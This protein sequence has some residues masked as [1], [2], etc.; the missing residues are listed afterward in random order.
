MCLIIETVPASMRDANCVPCY[1][2]W[3]KIWDCQTPIT[4]YRWTPIPRDGVLADKELTKKRLLNQEINGG[5]IH[6]KQKRENDT[7]RI[8]SK[9]YAFGVIAYGSKWGNDLACSLLYIPRLD[10]SP[11]KAKRMKQIA[12]WKR[13]NKGPTNSEVKRLFPNFLA[14]NP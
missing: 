4:P 14:P 13:A 11:Q 5:A 7:L 3:T 1:K 10:K 8:I 2:I 6:A 12:I 9:A